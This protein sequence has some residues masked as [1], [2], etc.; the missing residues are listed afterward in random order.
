MKKIPLVLLILLSISAFAQ[1]SKTHYIPPISCNNNLAYDHYFYISTP[2]TTN[3]NFKIIEI[4]GSTINGFVSSSTP[5]IYTIGSGANTQLMTPKTVIGKISN[6]GFIIEADDLVYVSMR[7]NSAL[8]NNNTAF[9]HAGGLVSKGNSALGTTFRLG[10]MFNPVYDSSVLNFSSI[11]ATEN[12]TKVTISNIPAG[13]ILTDG[14]VVSGPIVVNLNKN[15]SYVIALENYTNT[16]SNSS[17]LIGGLVQT[18]KPVVV[19]SGSFA[20]NNSTSSGRDVGFDQIVS[21]EK[22]GKEYIFV[23]GLGTNELER[24][25]L[26]AHKDNTSI[27]INGSSTP[28]KTINA[29]QYADINGSYF[30][31]GNLYIT[32]T[33]PVFAYQSIGGTNSAANQNLFFVPPINCTTPRTVNNIPLIQSIGTVT[34]TGGLNI[35][36]E[37]GAT[38]TINN[39]TISSSPVPVTGNPGFE[40]YTVNGLSGNIT[41]IS[42]KQVYVSYFGTNNAATYGGYYS[43]FDTKPEV[44]SNKISTTNSSCI[45]NIVLQTSTVSSY[46]AFQ[47]F[48]NGNPIIGA[49]S[50]IYTPT[51]PGY[52]NVQ[53]S[54]SGCPSTA[55]LLSDKIPVSECPSDHD[56]DN[57]NDNKD[58]DNDN[59]GISNC[60]ESYG[61]QNLNLSSNSG[62]VAVGSY[63]NSF[64]GNTTTSIAT[65]PTPYLGNSDGSFTT[66]IPTG[67]NS[68]MTRTLTFNQPITIGME[69]IETGNSADLINADAEYI[70]NSD[71]NK[72]ITVTNPSNQLLIDTNYDGIYESGVTEYS[73]FEIRFRLNSTTPLAAGTGDFKFS[74]YLTNTFSITHKNLSETNSN[75]SSFKLFAICV[76]KDT[77]GDGIPDQID[78]DSDNDGIPDRIEAQANT[79]LALTNADTNK[80]GIDNAFGNGLTPIDTDN[81]GVPDYL[82]WDSD[83]DG[84]ND[85]NES[86]TNATNPDIDNDGIKNYRE[87]DSDKDLCFDVIEAGYLDPNSD[88]I[89][90]NGPISI[91]SK[92][93]V[94]SAVGYTIPNNNYTIAAPILITNQ[95]LAPATCELEP[96]QISITDNGDS[97]QWEIST[98]GTTWTTLTNNTTYNGTT[99]NSLSISTVANNMNGYK[100]RVFINKNG[101]SCGLMSA[102]TSLT[103]YTLPSTNNITIVQC[104][105]DLDGFTAFNLTVKNN[106]ISANATNETFT[107]YTSQLGAS[108][109]NS[110]ELIANPLSFTNTTPS[111]MNVWARV[112]NSNNCFKI[113]QITLKVIATQIPLTFNRTFQNCDDFLDTNGN[114]NANNNKRDGIATFDFSSAE[115]D[116]KS[117]LPVGNYTVRFY[118]NQNDALA[119]IDP[120]AN[121]NNYRNIG[122][123]DTQQI[124]TRVDSDTDNACFG[125]GPYVTLNVE[126]NPFANPVIIPRQCDDNQDGIFIFNT[127]T[128]ES[129]L[130]NGQVN[131]TVSYFDSSNNP[132]RD[133]NGNLIT[134]PFPNSFS[135][136]SQTI[137]AVVTN[138]STLKCSEETTIEFIVDKLPQVFP[139]PNSLT[140]SC[141]DETDPLLQDGKFGFDSSTFES[142]L[143]GSQ[144]GMIVKYYDQNGN[145][146]PSPLPNP[147]I[148]SSQNIT[149]KV[150]N[151]I[152][153]NCTAVITIPFIV[154]PLPKININIDGNEDELICSNLPTFYVQLN[155]GIKDGSSTSN[156][157]YKWYKDNIALSNQTPTLDVNSEGVYT[158]EVTTKTTGCSRTRSM[159]VT[160]SDIATISSIE[161]NDLADSNSVTINATGLGD[162]EYSID[163]P[164]NSFQTSNLFNDVTSG[165]HTVYIRDINGCGTVNKVISVIGIP[166]FFTPNGDGHNDFWNIKGVNSSFNSKTIV[167]IFDRYGKLLKQINPLDQGWDGTYN[168]NQ[169]PADDY[170]FSIKL[171]DGREAKGHFTLKR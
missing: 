96:A 46:D 132:L 160:P 100:Y 60:T 8:N 145:A 81:D 94:T 86:G 47:W 43:G 126:K 166:K 11:L 82:D 54:I 95:P 156:Y 109:A 133:S 92:G 39:N 102:E 144:T 78:E 90:G 15:E 101:N 147:F 125:L 143:L 118:K 59:D 159:L 35:V 33:E 63:S 123:P 153:P 138:N 148:T 18:D 169:L 113:S 111:T 170:W 17:N 99:T 19:N 88:G 49:I 40:R 41:V 91:N 171:E 141:D 122:Y 73:S 155:A 97:Y 87:L 157:T 131:K 124:W 56:G 165:I 21:F 1:F 142:T 70:V 24:V 80:D 7:I 16:T 89:L 31:N 105:D 84:I 120:I 79:P 2:S 36:T 103:V 107:Y 163:D 26:I 116:I 112:T 130:L 9:N 53:G 154:H 5:Y 57:I 27:Y 65:S 135:T 28:F 13:A 140:I 117:L 115:T 52:Y 137:K 4:G 75:K 25:L 139:I 150:E 136:Q 129:T 83:N 51:S 42:T 106:D 146:L 22:T 10:A 37:T 14:T 30:N 34:Y 50:N 20:G 55:P 58:L 74:S 114:N 23:K 93:Q 61:N 32:T 127:T 110:A 134:S 67:L 62:V 119:E 161:I 152:N 158:V 167:Y 3:V 128:L 149:V 64:T 71:I 72:T 45:P 76:P 121:T 6:K 68:F 29:G 162:Y 168:N 164:N 77:D 44:V 66:E 69:Y 151:P 108:T 48:F 85:I 38:V 104:D 12:N 98:N